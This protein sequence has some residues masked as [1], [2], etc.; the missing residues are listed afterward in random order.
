MDQAEKEAK[1]WNAHDQMMWEIRDAVKQGVK[2]GIPALSDDEIRWVRLAILRE[3][4]R[5]ERWEAVVNK[6]LAGLAWSAIVGIGV[7]CLSYLREHGWK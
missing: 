4:K 1:E 7:I 3:G 5:A 6:S 2:D